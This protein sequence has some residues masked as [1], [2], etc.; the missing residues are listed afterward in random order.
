MAF[1]L[2]NRSTKTVSPINVTVSITYFDATDTP[3]TT[4]RQR[5][6]DLGADDV[7]QFVFDV[8]NDK[9]IRSAQ[10]SIDACQDRTVELKMI[11]TAVALLFGLMY[12][13]LS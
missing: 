2:K 4:D 1:K 12:R 11:L 3:V 5:C 7:H 6:D 13:L 9:A 8:P 10:I